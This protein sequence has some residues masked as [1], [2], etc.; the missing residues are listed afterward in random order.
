M[1]VERKL[2]SNQHNFLVLHAPILSARSKYDIALWLNYR[3][4]RQA[5]LLTGL[6]RTSSSLSSPRGN[7]AKGRNQATLKKN[8]GQ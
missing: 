3:P 4:D 6:C 1:S 7:S 2:L 5:S 8:S